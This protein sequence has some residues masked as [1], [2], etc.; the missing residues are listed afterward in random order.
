ML[1]RYLSCPAV[2]GEASVYCAGLGGI[3][4]VESGFALAVLVATIP[5]VAVAGSRGTTASRGSDLMSC[6][7]KV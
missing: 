6:S 4:E 5:S 2:D 7:R 3:E 1:P